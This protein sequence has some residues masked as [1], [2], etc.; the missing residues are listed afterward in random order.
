MRRLS[1]ILLL[2]VLLFNLY[3]YQVMLGYMQNKQFNQFQSSLDKQ[4]Y[5]EKDLISIK[6][7]LNL[8][9]YSSSADF[10]RAYGSVEINGMV[11]EYVKRRVN[12]DTLELLCLPNREKTHLQTTRN[13]FVKLSVDGV[14]SPLEKKST[15]HLKITL[16]DF[17]QEYVEIESVHSIAD[18]HTFFI[19]N[20]VLHHEDFSSV[21]KQPP[22]QC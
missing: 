12:Q 17:Y 2:T 16:P 6:T 11:Y 5:D 8:P 9:Y 13:A 3:G 22:R 19:S 20:T 15:N 14:T 21:G 7:P 1:A 18:R 4:Q 10:E